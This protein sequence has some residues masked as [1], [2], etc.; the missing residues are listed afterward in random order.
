MS[1]LSRAYLEDLKQLLATAT[2]GP[3]TAFLEGRDHDSGSS[4]IRTPG[5]DIELTGATSADLELIA[6]ARQDLPLL[7]A[8]LERLDAVLAGARS[9]AE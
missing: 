1:A 6:R 9:A 5:E 8:E 7:I 4:F 3:W 2:P